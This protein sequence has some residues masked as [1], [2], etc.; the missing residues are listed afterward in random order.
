MNSKANP[1]HW[2]SH[3]DIETGNCAMSINPKQHG[4]SCF[5][6][7]RVPES[8]YYRRATIKGWITQERLF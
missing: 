1:C 8:E 7:D 5:M 4:E 3:Y 2:C 6:Q